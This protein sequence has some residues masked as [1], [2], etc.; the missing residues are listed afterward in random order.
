M[1][2]YIQSDMQVTQ[3][4]YIVVKCMANTKASL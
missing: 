3:L 2:Y 4:L 1:H